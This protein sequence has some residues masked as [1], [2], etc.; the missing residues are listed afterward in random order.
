MPIPKND[1]LL[2]LARALR[3]EM[4]PHERR[5]W[6]CFLRTYPIK[7]YK[8]RIIG[9]YIADFYCAAAKLV[10]ELDGSQHF[11]QEE[12]AYDEKRDRFLRKQ[13][14]QVLRFGNHEINQYFDEV[15]EAID[16]AIQMR[17][18]EDRQRRQGP[19]RHG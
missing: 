1:A 7:I 6:Y 19:L 10:I 17:L 13:G 14:L 15:C 16:R 9:E 18:P 5:L 3:R 2:P 11:E 4:T 12:Q 8:Q